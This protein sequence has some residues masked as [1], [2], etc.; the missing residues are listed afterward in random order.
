MPRTIAV[1]VS[2]AEL[3]RPGYAA[4]VLEVC[5]RARV[6]PQSL[7]VEVT[8]TT[9]GREDEHVAANLIELRA[10][11]VG[12]SIDDFGTGYSSLSRLQ[13]MPVTQLKIDRA[14]VMLL[15]A[16]TTST[17]VL[18]AIVALARAMGLAIVAEG[19]ET[20][21]QAAGLIALGVR[22]G[23]G[24]HFARPMAAAD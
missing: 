12:V 10:A 22:H 13:L 24:Y 8:E 19:V 7:D 23:Q 16:E 1:N 11:G 6:A 21:A 4:E 2:H 3:C 20:S 18:V 9:L 17:P 14:F 15:D 5:A